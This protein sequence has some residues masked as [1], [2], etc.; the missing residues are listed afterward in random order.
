MSLKRK[1]LYI[2]AFIFVNISLIFGYVLFREATMANDLKKEIL[3]RN[4]TVPSDKNFSLKDR[5]EK[6]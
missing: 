1:I 3:T 6:L 5:K 2:V 4:K